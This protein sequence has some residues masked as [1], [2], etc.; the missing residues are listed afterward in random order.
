L[1]IIAGCEKYSTHPIAKSV[2]LAFGKFADDANV[3][4]PK[5][6]AGMGVS[7][8]IDGVT[9]YAGNEKLMEMAGVDFE[10]TSLVG[11]AIYCCSDSEFL[12]DIVFADIIKEDS[13]QAI[14]TMGKM[15]V[16]TTVMLTGDKQPIADDIA[17][18]AGIQTVYSRLLPDEKIEKIKELQDSGNKVFYTGDGI[19]DAPVLAVADLGIAMGAVGADVAIEASDIVIMGD[20]LSKIP[21]GI[22]V[23]RKALKLAKENIAFS[24]VVK[25]II[26]VLVVFLNKELPMWI[27]V[28][29]DVGVAI[30]AIVNSLRAMIVKKSNK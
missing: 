10:E 15:G 8:V 28:F 21:V 27:A 24:L 6:Y 22:R 29:G 17:Q 7:A 13:K 26:L 20:S 12:G 16:K 18:K 3:T 4:N 1:R 11:T 5:N 19:N 9:Y 25:T 2:N 14:A 23:A 30:I